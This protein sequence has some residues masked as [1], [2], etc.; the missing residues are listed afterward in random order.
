[1]CIG[2]SGT[3]TEWCEVIS[4]TKATNLKSEIR[5]WIEDRPNFNALEIVHEVGEQ[6][7]LKWT[8]RN[9]HDF[10]YLTVEP[11]LWSMILVYILTLVLSIFVMILMISNEFDNNPIGESKYGYGYNRRYESNFMTKLFKFKNKK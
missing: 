5:N 1:V 3:K 2:K 9:F 4:W 6:S 11:P 10:D 7:R 8:R